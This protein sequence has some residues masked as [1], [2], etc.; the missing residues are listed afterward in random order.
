MSIWTLWVPDYGLVGLIKAF[1]AVVSIATATALWPLLPK[2][3]ALP[4]PNQLRTANKALEA[5]IAER[6]RAL[7][8][9][10]E[11]NAQ[12]QKVEDMLR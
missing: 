2:A 6:D 4:S 12:R 8:A 7:A 3:L 10:A 5:G 1:T 11:A 9:L